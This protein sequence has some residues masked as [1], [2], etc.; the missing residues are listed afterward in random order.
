MGKAGDEWV[1]SEVVENEK[2]RGGLRRSRVREGKGEGEDWVFEGGGGGGE[3][4]E[5]KSKAS[6]QVTV[7]R[8]LT[9]NKK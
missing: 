4:S 5:A 9:S 8:S 3:G 7:R 2:V 6:R 1:L